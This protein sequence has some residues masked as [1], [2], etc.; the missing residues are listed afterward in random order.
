MIQ[1]VVPSLWF[2]DNNAEEAVTYYCAV[3]PDARI[4]DIVRYPDEKLDEHFA[5][6]AGKVLVI[7]FEL[8][9][10]RL[11]A[12]DGGPHFR[13]DEA[14][15]L[16]VACDSQ[17]E[18]DWYWSK[19]SHVPQSEQCGWCKDRFGLSWQIVPRDIKRLTATDEAMR[20]LLGMKKIDI[21]ALEAAV[22]RP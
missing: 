20:L 14:F 11:Q 15:S 6:M 5:G 3:F 2:A 22:K 10:L 8:G 12:N 4:L 16:S 1:R 9:G 17:Q 7:T 19:L 21:A 18:I 13:L